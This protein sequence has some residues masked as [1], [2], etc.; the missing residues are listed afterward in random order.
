MSTKSETKAKKS[1]KELSV[2]ENAA[3]L[4]DT[5]TEDDM[6][7]TS[8]STKASEKKSTA[9]KA[10]KETAESE[11]KEAEVKAEAKAE[12][13]A[14]VKAEAKAEEKEEVKAAEI[15]PMVKKVKEEVHTSLYVQYLGNEIESSAIIEAV[16]KAFISKGGAES[17]IKTLDVYIKPEDNA[18]YYVINKD[19]TGRVALV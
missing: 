14:E 4:V 11:A 13:K 5:V 7:K 16:K 17:E 3:A 2:E 6:V 18:A 15:K 9:K 12:E 8:K 19:E 10:K 1:G